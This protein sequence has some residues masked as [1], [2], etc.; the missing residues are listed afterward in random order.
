M[1]RTLLLTSAVL[2]IGL[3]AETPKVALLE[4]EIA[5][6]VSYRL[7]VA[8]VSKLASAPGM[9]PPIVDRGFVGFLGVG[10]IVAVNGKPAKGMW[11]NRGEILNASPTPSP[12]MAI[13]DVGSGSHTQCTID[14]YTADG[15]WVGKLV[16]RGLTPNIGG[17]T[18]PII[19]G[20]GAYVGAV[21]EHGWSTTISPMR[22]TSALES[23]GLRQAIGGGRILVQY[24][25][26]PREWPAVEV[27]ADGPSVFHAADMSPVTASNPARADEVLTIRAKGLGPTRPTL[28]PAGYKPF[29]VDP[30]EEVNSPVEATI[31]GV[32]ARVVN[33]VGW[34]GTFDRYRVDVQVPAGVQPRIAALRLTAAW[35]PGD[36]VQIPVR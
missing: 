33:K 10:D 9:V 18:H 35:I 17:P 26:I 16:D 20:S 3:A 11:A 12:T 6:T 13:G 22:R 5:N 25:V 32:N 7:D 2:V 29:G 34:P 24:Y 31:G 23:P 21:G 30:L 15:Q 28:I 8:D 1:S 4:I 27:T 14:L 19:G 36:E